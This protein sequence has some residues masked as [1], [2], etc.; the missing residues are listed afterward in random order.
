MTSQVLRLFVGTIAGPLGPKTPL[1][2]YAIKQPDGV[3]LIDTGMNDPGDAEWAKTW[4]LEIRPITDALADHRLTTN[5]VTTVVM[6]HLDHDHSGN[7][8]L[9][10]NAPIVVQQAEVEHQRATLPEDMRAHW[11]FEGANFRLLDGDE[12]LTPDLLVV[13][14]PGHTPGHQSILVGHGDDTELIV[15][16]AAYTYDLW[17]LQDDFDETHPAYSIQIR[18]DKKTWLSSLEKLRDFKAQTLFFGHDDRVVTNS[19]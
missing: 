7:N 3:V 4:P 9:F 1:Y 5:D 18:T 13:A 19:H 11:D 2:S 15:G 10:P 16:D 12:R 6:T 8:T 17:Q 14:T